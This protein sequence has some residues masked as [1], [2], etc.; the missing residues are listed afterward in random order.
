LGFFNFFGKF[1]WGGYLGS[2]ENPCR[3][4]RILTATTIKLQIKVK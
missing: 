2:W 3:S 1:C 4:Q